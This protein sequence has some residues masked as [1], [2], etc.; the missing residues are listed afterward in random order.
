MYCVGSIQGVY[1][2]IYIYMQE[3]LIWGFLGMIFPYSLPPTIRY[4][5]GSGRGLVLAWELLCCASGK[6][7]DVS[8]ELIVPLKYIK[9][10]FG[11][12]IIRTP[13]TP[14]FIY[15]RGMIEFKVYLSNGQGTKD[16]G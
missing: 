10:G 16:P 7:L 15:L 12:I 4:I 8:L 3:N 2:H 11:Y 13:Y 1:I 6:A 5:E 9:Y 14:Y